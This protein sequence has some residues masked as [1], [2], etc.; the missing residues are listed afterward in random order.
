MR[1]VKVLT[2]NVHSCRGTD[3]V[4]DP[5][6]IAEVIARCEP[7]V[8]A[9]QELD[10]GR[11]R[12][13]GTDQAHQIATSLRM[14]SHFHPAL[15]LE[16]E[17]YGDAILTL[18]PSRLI[19]AGP[20]PSTGEPRGALWAAV[21]LGGTELHVFNT[22]LGL[23]RRERV[24]QVVELLGPKW[25]GSDKCRSAFSILLGDLNAVPRSLAYRHVAGRLR[26]A[27][28]EAGR[29]P[30]PTFPSRFPLL[31]IDHVFIGEGIQAVEVT[32]PSAGSARTASDHLPLLV[33]IAVSVE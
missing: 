5:N 24:R 9:L 17:L 6:R 21:D 11:A 12:S 33:T 30:W 1:Q 16:E 3:G 10:V 29:R 15:H 26:D 22:H 23:R 18:L 13:G 8:V 4:T 31:R 20:L 2:Y 27:Q 25:L 7:D 32:V 19:Q 28:V 14:T